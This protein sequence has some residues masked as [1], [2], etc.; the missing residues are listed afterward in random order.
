MN[1]A[2]ER[3]RTADTLAIRHLFRIPKEGGK[4]QMLAACFPWGSHSFRHPGTDQFFYS[5]KLIGGIAGY[6]T[7]S[8]SLLQAAA[9]QCI[10]FVFSC[11]QVS[12]P[13]A[14]LDSDD[15]SGGIPECH[16]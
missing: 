12:H 3:E 15:F 13:I 6:G 14:H 8:Y 16:P 10:R 7:R 1:R 2:S 4:P 9:W 11:Y 5:L